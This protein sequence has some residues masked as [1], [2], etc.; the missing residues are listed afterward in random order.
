MYI[1]KDFVKRLVAIVVAICAY[2]A[3]LATL[4]RAEITG[5]VGCN[6]GEL[7]IVNCDKEAVW[8]VYPAE[9]AVSYAVSENGKTVYFASPKEG[10]VTFFA[11]SVVDG[12]PCLESHSLYNGLKIP[13]PE[14]TPAP[15]PVPVPVPEPEP[16]PVK[17]ELEKAIDMAE[18]YPAQDV[19]ALADTF[20][21]VVGGIDRGTI[22]TPIAAREAFRA[23]WT[24]RASAVNP[25]AITAIEPLLAKI[26][27][28]IDN[29]NLGT[30]RRDYNLVAKGIRRDETSA[31]QEPEETED[32]EPESEPEE[33]QKKGNC[34]NGQCP[35][36]NCPNGQCPAT[37]QR[38]FWRQ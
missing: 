6:A 32:P 36:G 33:T 12:R 13:E 18:D 25:K 29:T 16:K 22:A 38:F 1:S 37:P 7:A 27:A 9:Y 28:A 5:A 20:E 34:P 14:P 19:N 24:A 26:S 2:F 35:T 30:I 15:E 23:M 3:I 4:A 21:A 31:G 10:K 17:T 11:A 8:S